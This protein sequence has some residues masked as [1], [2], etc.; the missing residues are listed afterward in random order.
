M[1]SEDNKRIAKNTIYLY[2]RQFVSML[3]SLYTFRLILELLGVD[4]YGVYNVIGG[5]VVLFSFL[6]GTMMQSSQRYFSYY[7]GRKNEQGLHDIFRMSINMH[8]ILCGIIFV[9]ANTVGLWFIFTHM[10]FPG[11]SPTTVFL[12]FECSTLSFMVNVWNIPYRAMVI[13]QERMNFFAY[14]SVIEVVMKLVVVGVL[15]LWKGNRLVIYSACEPLV[16]IIFSLW[17]VTYNVRHFAV[18]RY[19]RFWNKS[20][21]REL[22]GF[23][24]WNL[25]GAIG[26]LSSQQGINILFNIFCGLG[27]N[28][29]M[30][31]SNKVTSAIVS[32]TTNF[33]T[34]FNPQIIKFYSAEKWNEFNTLVFRASR[35]SFLLLF[36]LAVPI[37][38]CC[39]EILHLWLKEVPADSVSFIQLAIVFSLIDALS[40]PLWTSAQATGNIKNYMLLIASMI[41]ATLPI[42]YVMLKLGCSPIMVIGMRV[43]MNFIIHIVRIFYLSKMI[44]LF[45]VVRY[46][47]EVMKPAAIAILIAFPLPYLLYSQI[48]GFG[49][50]CLYGTLFLLEATVIGYIVLLTKHERDVI[51]TKVIN[52]VSSWKRKI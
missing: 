52:I 44:R 10:R 42:A 19:S 38:S 4:N 18:A 48:Q 28:A 12:V 15:F 11:T 50:L 3:V 51:Q 36:I 33:Q 13:A 43:L 30:G 22:T 17:Y 6:S 47:S 24:T 23:S 21:L 35:I 40:S 14:L 26:N 8:L 45:S 27:V 46:F 9:L 29:A 20:I 34:S 16:S 2:I 5:I 1:A 37:I 31:I 39:N 49:M 32:F 41:F 25:L 7:L